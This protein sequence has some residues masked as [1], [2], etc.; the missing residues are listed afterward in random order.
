MIHFNPSAP[1]STRTPLDPQ[2]SSVLQTV[3]AKGD[4]LAQG[5]FC[6]KL[7]PTDTN[8]YLP[9]KTGWVTLPFDLFYFVS[10]YREAR[11]LADGEVLEATV[12][13]AAVLPFGLT[14]AAFSMVANTID[15]C[16]FLQLAK[17][18][19]F[20]APFLKRLHI[21]GLVLATGDLV[22]QIRDLYREISL[23][24]VLQNRT[25][26]LKNLYEGFLKPRQWE[27]V[28]RKTQD[29]VVSLLNSDVNRAAHTLSVEMVKRQY[30]LAHRIR[31][32]AVEDLKAGLSDSFL[33]NLDQPENQQKGDLLL[34]IAKTQ[35]FKKIL[36]HLLGVASG[37]LSVVGVVA[38][39]LGALW[40]IPLGLLTAWSIVYSVKFLLARGTLEQRGW[41]F[42][43]ADCI[44]EWIHIGWRKVNSLAKG[45]LSRLQGPLREQKLLA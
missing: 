41:K 17:V 26:A 43:V 44:P 29:T 24:F 8:P 11:L 36:V 13:K 35:N 15:I 25:T 2:Q 28:S 18:F 20:S 39:L 6:K 4:K 3:I 32:W 45:V 42:S 40:W 23:F 16:L 30:V 19:Q 27:T 10:Q 21:F 12:V 14:H 1:Q 37:A 38:V 9:G 34:K 33:L 31:S 22:F 5:H 7:D